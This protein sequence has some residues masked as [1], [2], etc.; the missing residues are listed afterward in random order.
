MVISQ[1]SEGSWIDS[2]FFVS[3]VLTP[4]RKNSPLTNCLLCCSDCCSLKCLLFV[5][6][7]VFVLYYLFDTGGGHTGADAP[8]GK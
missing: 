5:F 4:R 6:A 7:C 8:H 3:P 2:V 1:E